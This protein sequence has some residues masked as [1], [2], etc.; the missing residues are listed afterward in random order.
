MNKEIGEATR[1]WQPQ[2]KVSLRE[3]GNS[4]DLLSHIA[5]DTVLP[6]LRGAKGPTEPETPKNSK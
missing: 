3:D 5:V 1:S 2:Q 4:K 6:V